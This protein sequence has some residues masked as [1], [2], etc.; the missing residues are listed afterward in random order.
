[1]P[2]RWNL[3]MFADFDLL[4]PARAAECPFLM[5]GFMIWE[6]GQNP[7]VD[8]PYYWELREV[9]DVG[10]PIWFFTKE[11][12]YRAMSGTLKIQELETMPSLLKGTADHYCEILDR[13]AS[14]Y[15]LTINAVGDLEDGRSFHMYYDERSGASRLTVTLK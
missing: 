1:V 10:V 11:D 14:D 9:K 5:E 4:D 2:N 12:K 6:D 7:Y 13:G 8:Q 15:Q 3:L